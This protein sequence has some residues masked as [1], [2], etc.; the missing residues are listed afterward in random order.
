[1]DERPRLLVTLEGYAVE[2]GMDRPYEPATCY[3]PTIALGRHEGPGDGDGLWRDYEAVLDLIPDLGFAGVRISVEWARV[4]PRRGAIDTGALDRYALGVTHALAL[5]L[6]VT[7]V[8]VDA[9][10]P[11][12][13]G[14]EAWL[15]PWVAPDMVA[16]ARRVVAHLGDLDVGVV[17]FADPQRL[18]AGGFLD[19]TVP[20]WRTG[21]SADARSARSQL[22]SI[23]AAL[24]ADDLVGSRLVRSHR[25][26]SLDQ[27]IDEIVAARAAGDVDELY[28]RSMLRGSGPTA[29][30]RGL[31]SRRNDLWVRDASAALLDALR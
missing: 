26:I 16:H 20:P 24:E 27:P 5:G 2:G 10:W 28:V 11:A 9:A 3:R 12:W 8:L 14:L 4:E 1:M 15:L 7:I 19:A 29:A 31:V 30:R 21:A 23:D 6:D 13:L 25:S 17:G 18:V 22:A